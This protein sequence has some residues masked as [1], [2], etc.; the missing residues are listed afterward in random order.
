MARKLPARAARPPAT[1]RSPVAPPTA[2][3]SM[4]PLFVAA[5]PIRR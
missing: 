5:E 2:A 4:P 1:A 3:P